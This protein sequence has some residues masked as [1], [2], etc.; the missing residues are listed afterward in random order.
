MNFLVDNPL[1]PVVAESL[2]QAGHDAVHVRDYGMQAAED[3]EIFRSFRDYRGLL[4]THRIFLPLTS[5][6]KGEGGE[7]EKNAPGIPL[8]PVSLGIRG[9]LRPGRSPFLDG[10][11]PPV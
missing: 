2:R 9:R 5:P 4:P 8:Q 3:V 6:A 1:S 11:H 10:S 7:G